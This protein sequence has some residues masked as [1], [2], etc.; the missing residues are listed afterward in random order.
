MTP[1]DT[2]GAI[3]YVVS[4][5][6]MSTDG[7]SVVDISDADG[8]AMSLVSAT[9]SRPTVGPSLD[10]RSGIALSHVSGSMLTSQVGG[11]VG[12]CVPHWMWAL[13]SHSLVNTYCGVTRMGPAGPA[14]V[15]SY[16]GCNG[17]TMWGGR[18]GNGAPAWGTDSGVHL[19]EKWYDG[20]SSYVARDGEMVAGAV[21][22]G[23]A[24]TSAEVGIGGGYGGTADSVVW[25]AGWGLGDAYS[26]RRADVARWVRSVF[27]SMELPPRVVCSGDSQTAGNGPVY[28]WPQR[29]A[30]SSLVIDVRAAYPSWTCADVLSC[31]GYAAQVSAG[32]SG[33]R[34][35]DVAVVWVGTNTLYFGG[36][37]D[38][39]WAGVDQI[40]RGYE[41]SGRRVLVLTC[42]DRKQQGTP[43]SYEP[44]R[45]DLNRRIMASVS[46]TRSIVDV[47]SMPE[48]AD[49]ANAQWFQADAV[50]LSQ[51]GHDLLARRIASRLS[52][53]TFC[54]V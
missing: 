19:M 40:C 25:A 9:A 35:A 36:S 17:P 32:A 26:R 15:N 1:N 18:G 16:L 48:F 24:F 28:P 30:V 38:M 31:P 42:L 46:A 53:A 21:D 49:S 13:C 6:R 27:P 52:V 23:Y 22:V 43:T 20:V 5:V 2:P 41:S 4:G 54:G 10:G 37:A 39:A 11:I 7:A 3:G 29:L 14:A 45:L 12:E 33:L 51:A 47:A 34:R 8:G 50:H 44:A